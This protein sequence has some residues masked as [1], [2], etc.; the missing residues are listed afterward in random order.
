MSNAEVTK[1]E[2]FSRI[3]SGASDSQ[4]TVLD[5]LADLRP[6]VVALDSAS[7]D[8]RGQHN[9]QR[10]LALPDHVPEVHA[11]SGQRSLRSDVPEMRSQLG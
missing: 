3:F 8:D 7:L 1:D 11:G 2:I 10:R 9:D 4:S 5:G 6:V